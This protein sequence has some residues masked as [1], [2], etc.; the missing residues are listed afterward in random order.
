MI[1]IATLV[2]L[3]SAAMPAKQASKVDPATVIH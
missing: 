2:G 1:L 3:V